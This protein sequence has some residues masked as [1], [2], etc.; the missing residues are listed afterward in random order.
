MSASEVLPAFWK[1]L[2]THKLIMPEKGGNV[3][4]FKCDDKLRAVF[5]AD[6]VPMTETKDRIQKHLSR[7]SELQLTLD[8]VEG[9][10]SGPL[11]AAP[12]EAAVAAAAAAPDA[13]SRSPHNLNC[14]DLM[15]VLTATREYVTQ[16]A[17][18]SKAAAATAIDDR[19]YEQQSERAM[20][21]LLRS[22][23]ER[24]RR[25][26]FFLGFAENPSLFITDMMEAHGL[27]LRQVPAPAGAPEGGAPAH[28]AMDR[29][30]LFG[31]GQWVDEASMRLMF[32]ELRM[33]PQ[34]GDV[35]GGGQGGAADPGPAMMFTPG[36][37]PN[38]A[39]TPGPTPPTTG[40]GGPGA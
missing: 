8:L 26:A 24:R 4:F 13:P 27:D 23:D 16:M 22:L 5:D 28:V 14:Y 9:P 31:T 30:S 2:E 1:Y 29:S 18:E 35:M 37:A 19:A 38:G 3:S 40:H 20:L 6:T 34:Q 33:A 7:P 21:E 39:A 25:R 15:L 11:C 17:C 10:F 12:K 32:K 36:G